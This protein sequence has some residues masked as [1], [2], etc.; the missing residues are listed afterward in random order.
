[1]PL[2]HYLFIVCWMLGVSFR[3]SAQENN[4]FNM[5]A[6]FSYLTI[7]EG[8]SSNTVR[9]LM[10]DKKGFVWVG[11]SRGL[12]RFDGHRMVSLR[13]TRS[14]SV[15]SMAEWGDSIWVGADNG[16]Y[17][18]LQR[19]D[20]IRKYPVQ[21]QGVPSESLNVADLKIDTKGMLWMAT[22]GQ[23]ILCLNT[24]TGECR[25]VPVPEDSKSYG[26]V[27]I[28]KKGVVWASSNWAASNLVRYNE[29]KK[30]FESPLPTSP[31]GGQERGF[32]GLALTEDASGKMWLGAWEGSLICFDPSN[33]QAEMVLTPSASQMLH[34]HS[35]LPLTKTTMLIGSDKGLA[36]VDVM[37]KQ[38]HL[39]H[40]SSSLSNALSDNFVY[41]LM[42][43][44]EGGTW[45]GTFYGGVNY[46]HPVSGNFTSYIHTDHQN[47]VSGNV[48]NHFCED[49]KNR[50]WIASDD[51]GL[52]YYT[53]DNGQFTKVSLAQQGEEHN[54]HALSMDGDMLYVGTYSQGMD[55]VDVN[56]MT[57]THVPR[58]MDEQG[59]YFDASSYAI[60]C[61]R[62]H[63]IWVGTFH[64]VALFHPDTRTFSDVQPVGG[65]VVDI[66]QDYTDAVW[67]AT[68]GNGLW[69][70]GKS[71]KW[72]HYLDFEGKEKNDG[73]LIS[74]N[75][76]FE[77]GQGTLWVGMANGLFRY[78]R[79]EDRFVKVSLLQEEVSVYGITAVEGHLWLTT[80][81]GILCYSLPKQEVEQVYKGG[82]NIASIDF[83]PDAIFR[84]YD[85]KVY[86]G[87][88]NG[89]VAF[90]P[91]YMHRNE[92]QP[93][94]LFTSLEIFNRPVPVGGEILP[95]R[96]P[97]LD[98]LRL[99]YRESVF[100]ISFSAM[101]YLNPSDIAYSYYLEGFDEDWTE[102]GNQQS[103]TY[104]NLEPGTYTLHVK[105]VTNDGM[106]SE[107]ATLRIVI[108]PP[109]YWNTPAKMLYLL[110]IIAAIFFFVRHL[111]HKKE[112][113]H[114]AEIQEINVQKEHEIQEINNQKEQEIQ[115]INIQK[116]QEV[117][118]ARIKFMTIT[119][120]DQAFL[121]K[122]EEVIEQNFSNAD[123][124]VDYLAS[125]LNVS[126]SG[127][128]AK[129]KALAD[130]T[131]NEMIQ[132]IRLKHAASLLSSGNY[133]VNE[134][135]YMVGFSSP[136][137][138]AKCF[139]KQ[140]GCTPAKYK[141]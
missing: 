67:V 125:E 47:S 100:R 61:D 99:S 32:G 87:T 31:K 15:T 74:A 123:L 132:V 124:T 129:I 45:I 116:E 17:L 79:E 3:L 60:C 52:C 53:P 62:Q 96:L 5:S 110:L 118:D 19:T 138:F 4:P 95:Q 36:L 76:L 128:F 126:R 26:C 55:M 80:S 39:C 135:C 141:G 91:Q 28:D 10:Q 18:Y 1:M 131:P 34:I 12:N 11:T 40:R 109:F 90:M 105:A 75:S 73:A 25:A 23:G 112:R 102:A 59:K 54:V 83:L 21:P 41:P 6:S 27:Y 133:R 16:L 64:E 24:Q 86:I 58:F 14:I 139:Q 22:M 111:L 115:E 108:T 81:A 134:V 84:G 98:E 72:K 137:Y 120:K 77:D 68:E 9:A 71:G 140:Y 101:S 56:T 130:V 63:R 106:Q 82:G 50:L 103:V 127:L 65:P 38:V 42:Q 94:V 92:V 93:Q 48:V 117:H 51:G 114:V 35:I 44:R 2:R 88:T 78:D 113:R 43:D 20:S 89:F 29:E 97:Y 119:D 57:V 33:H 122:M 104:T 30:V 49:H 70:Y 7:N 121:D 46:T 107:D 37:T 13:K 69:A 85:G 66:L 136:S 8:L